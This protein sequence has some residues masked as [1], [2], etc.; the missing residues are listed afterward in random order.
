MQNI[1]NSEVQKV[2]EIQIT[3]NIGLVKIGASLLIAIASYFLFPGY[4]VIPI[5][6]M[7]IGIAM[8]IFP[9]IKP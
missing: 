7:I 6:C 2:E 5:G 1:K 4:I 8:A 3:K 9:Q